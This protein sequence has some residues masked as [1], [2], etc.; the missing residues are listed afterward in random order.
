MMTHLVYKDGQKNTVP[1]INILPH[2]VFLPTRGLLHTHTV[3][4]ISTEAL[5]TSQ[6][7]HAHFATP[8]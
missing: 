2:L 7:A 4:A 3:L 1:P 6:N 5:C 8:Q